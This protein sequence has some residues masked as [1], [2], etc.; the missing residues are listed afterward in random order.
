MELSSF[1]ASHREALLAEWENDAR[2]RIAED[3]DL[4]IDQLRDHLGEL[5]DSVARELA[6]HGSSRGESA[7]HGTASNAENG[8]DAVAQR[9]GARRARQGMTVRQVVSEF[10]MLRSCISR[11]WLRSLASRSVADVE[12]LIRFDEE[13]DRALTKSVTE[14]MEQLDRSR[15]T[16]LG[17][18]SH[19]LRDPLATVIAG[20]QLLLEG[21]VSAETSHEVVKRIVS[22]GKRMHHLVADLLDAVRAQLGGQLSLERR[23][24]DL[25]DTLRNIVGEFA[26]AHPDREMRL[27]LAGDLQ[28]QWDDR[29]LGQA[30]ANLVTNA[31]RYGKPASPIDLSIAAEDSEVTI[32]VHNEGPAIPEDRRASLFEPF[33]VVGD[34][35]A[36]AG[37]RQRLRLGLF[38]AKAIVDGHHGHIEVESTDEGGTTFIIHLPRRQPM[39]SMRFE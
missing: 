24:A 11:L 9:H 23:D 15:D 27:S 4:D 2:Q 6:N 34:R 29:R 3:H 14:F 32:A 10:P 35:G 20:G 1:I 22:T 21:G 17:V 5:L 26:T 39:K 30:V 25:G 36:H 33:G 38:I 13:I 12:S 16:F 28:G 18:L 31:V 8:V 19:D 37:D 7:R